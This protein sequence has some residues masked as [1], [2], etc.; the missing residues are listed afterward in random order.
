[1]KEIQHASKILELIDSFL[2]K[3]AEYYFLRNIHSIEYSELLSNFMQSGFIYFR[4]PFM[5]VR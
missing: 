1:M 2:L 5:Y 4:K 3:L